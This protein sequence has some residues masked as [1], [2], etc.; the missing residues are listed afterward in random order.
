MMLAVTSISISG[1]I[2]FLI[3]LAV[4][5]LLIVGVKWLLGLAGVVV[6]P[7]IWAVLGFILFLVILLYFLGFIGGAPGVSFR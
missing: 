6:P 7:P 5:V 4:L 3:A 2:Y 1:V